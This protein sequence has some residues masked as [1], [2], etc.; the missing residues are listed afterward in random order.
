MGYVNPGLVRN[1]E[2]RYESGKS[3]FRWV[4]FV[5]NLMTGYSKKN[6]ENY[7]KKGFWIKEKETRVKI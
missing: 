2:F 1:F 7:L 5:Y 3:R 4:L 6:R